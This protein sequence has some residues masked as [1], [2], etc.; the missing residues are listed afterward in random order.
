MDEKDFD[1]CGRQL[2][3]HEHEQKSWK[4]SHLGIRAKASNQR[5]MRSNA[6]N[7]TVKVVY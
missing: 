4:L 3:A 6:E 1:R 5:T 2:Q 7:K